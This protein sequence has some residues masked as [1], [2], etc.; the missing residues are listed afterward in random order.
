M[1][2]KRRLPGA[3]ERLKVGRRLITVSGVTISPC[4]EAERTDKRK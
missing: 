1:I 2:R 4:S 3:G